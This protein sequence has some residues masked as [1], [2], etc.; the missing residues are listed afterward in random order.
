MPVGGLFLRHRE[1][2]YTVP[3]NEGVISGE[4]PDDGLSEKEKEKLQKIDEEEHNEEAH[5]E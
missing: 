4:P 1:L 5:E 3:V 2:S